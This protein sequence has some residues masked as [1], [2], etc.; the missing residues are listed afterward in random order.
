[1]ETDRGC[2]KQKAGTRLQLHNLNSWFESGDEPC[3]ITRGRKCKSYRNDQQ[4]A[5]V[6]D[7]LL[8]HCSLT[9]QHVSSDIIAHH[10][11]LLNC[12]YSN[13]LNKNANQMYFVLKSLK[14][15]LYYS[16]LHVSDT[17]VSIIRSFSV[18]HAVSGTV[19]CLVRCVIQSCYVVAVTTQ[20]DWRTQRTKHHTGSETACAA[21]K[22]LMMGTVVSE[23]CRAE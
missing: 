21:E 11:E 2:V 7:S 13:N 3:V 14:F 20:Q 23:T 5:T 15:C 4:D 12:N 9:A 6:Q 16:A 22:L 10:Q 18:A 8:F 19:W 1:M 17:T